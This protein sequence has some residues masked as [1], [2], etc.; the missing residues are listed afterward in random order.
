MPVAQRPKMPKTLP[1]LYQYKL[2]MTHLFL[3]RARQQHS[4]SALDVAQECLQTSRIK[5]ANIAVTSFQGVRLVNK[6][7][8][9]AKSAKGVILSTNRREFGDA[10]AAQNSG[11]L[12]EHVH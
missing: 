8:L 9:I 10:R 5:P 2:A 4:F 1:A 12:A 11:R 7:V 3:T 6:A